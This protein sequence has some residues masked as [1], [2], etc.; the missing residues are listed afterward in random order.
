MLHEAESPE[1]RDKRGHSIF[2]HKGN[3]E[4]VVG[5]EDVHNVPLCDIIVTVHI[6]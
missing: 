5:G 2:Y 3:V 1:I 6:K 4:D